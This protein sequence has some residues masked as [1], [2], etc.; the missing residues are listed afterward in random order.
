[1]PLDKSL[2]TT[3]FEPAT[4]TNAISPG[5]T[6]L[7]EHSPAWEQLKSAPRPSPQGHYRRGAAPRVAGTE[8]HAGDSKGCWTQWCHDSRG[9]P[10]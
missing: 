6:L 9:Q 10:D 4:A 5:V 3:G 1:M 8:P 2:G 7:I